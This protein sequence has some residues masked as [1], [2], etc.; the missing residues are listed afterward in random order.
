MKRVEAGAQGEHKLARG[1][2]PV[3]TRSA[4][5]IADRRFREAISIY[6]VRERAEIDRAMSALAEASPFRRVTS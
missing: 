6:L 3:V 2:E 4:H 5:W 1:Y